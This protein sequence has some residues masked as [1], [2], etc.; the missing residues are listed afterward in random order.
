MMYS[1]HQDYQGRQGVTGMLGGNRGTRSTR[2]TTSA[3]GIISEVPIGYEEQ[4]DAWGCQGYQPVE[5]EI[6]E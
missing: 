5:P 4:Q 1:K 6:S 2:G 3:R